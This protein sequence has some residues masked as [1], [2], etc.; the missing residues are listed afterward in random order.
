MELGGD[1]K[2]VLLAAALMFLL[3]LVLGVWKWRQMATADDGLA[4]PYVDTGHRAA[5]LYS[6]AL[7]L[8]ATFVELSGWGTAVNLI[9]AGAMTL[10]FFAAVVGYIVHGWLRDTDNQFRDPVAGTHGFMIS[11][12]AAEIGGWLVLIAGFVD[13]Q[14]L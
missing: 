3:A 13:R 4:H 6:F 9:A 14:I 12:I 1:T 2:A 10:Y 7:L 5:L 8:V 11:L